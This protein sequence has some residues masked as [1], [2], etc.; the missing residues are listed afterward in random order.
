MRF[1]VWKTDLVAKVGDLNENEWWFQDYPRARLP[2]RTKSYRLAM[3]DKYDAI[4]GNFKLVASNLL[5]LEI[6][7]F[8]K[9][10]IC[11]LVRQDLNHPFP[12]EG[13]RGVAGYCYGNTC[14]E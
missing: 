6:S 12:G 9:P 10:V 3:L 1:L 2:N 8:C 13:N 7:P 5:C 14:Y 4:S 11:D